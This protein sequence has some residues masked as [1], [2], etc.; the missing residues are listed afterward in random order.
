MSQKL[1]V[2]ALGLAI[3]RLG[4]GQVS[5]LNPAVL[6]LLSGHR[7]MEPSRYADYERRLMAL[8]ANENLQALYA[9][10]GEDSSSQAGP[11]KPRKP[12]Q[13]AG[14]IALIPLCGPLQKDADWMMRYFGG[15]STRAFVALCNMAAGDPDVTTLCIVADSPG[16]DVDGTAEAAD[17][18][19]A[20]RM[21]GK[22]PV[23]AYV[24]GWCCS[25]A[26]WIC[27]Q[28]SQ[29]YA[30]PTTING[31]IGTRWSMVDT[32]AAFELMGLKKLEITTG[33]YKAAGANGLPITEEDIAYFQ[34]IVTDMQTRFSAGVVRGRKLS[35]D[36]VRALAGEA[37]IFVGKTAQDAGLIDGILSVGDFIKQLQKQAGTGSSNS[38]TSTAKSG[39]TTAGSGTGENM[40][41][42]EKF[43][44]L[45]NEANS[46]A[47]D[48]VQDPQEV[49]NLRA[50]VTA[51][52]G[53]KAKLTA[54][55]TAEKAVLT[56]QVTTLTAEKTTLT[57]DKEGL[58]AK[59]RTHQTEEDAKAA[60]ALTDARAS[61]LKAATTAF[62]AGSQQ[63]EHVKHLIEAQTNPG[64][65]TSMT[66]AYQSAIPEHLR[67]GAGQQTEVPG[68]ITPEQSPEDFYASVRAE[69]EKANRNP[70]K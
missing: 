52:T 26:Y 22:K 35:T 62:G 55:F 20:I 69:G 12:Y 31:S 46:P 68:Q 25:A 63:L 51:L 40:D 13:M 34:G 5:S 41:F 36:A 47:Q 1:K 42:I 2:A 48:D 17:A 50:Q 6:P 9:D 66:G 59:V 23:V 4:A 37:R 10:D 15:T 19:Y 53:E 70:S 61:A 27:S 60:N 24:D 11:G 44:A 65:L 3:S 67:P 32:S 14:G 29:I 56:A 49:V 54:G 28:A 30:G 43:K 7:A 58:E 38:S 39:S 57:A 8:P 21:A 33:K 45:Y 18:V 16:G 64:I